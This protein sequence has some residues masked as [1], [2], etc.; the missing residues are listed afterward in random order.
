MSVFFH[1]STEVQSP[2]FRPFLFKICRAPEFFSRRFFQSSIRVCEPYKSYKAGMVGQDMLQ[3]GYGTN[4]VCLIAD[5]TNQVCYKTI[6]LSE[7]SFGL[8]VLHVGLLV[9]STPRVV[10]MA[11][12]AIPIPTGRGKLPLCV[13]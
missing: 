5:A 3:I 11:E 4:P 8:D 9:L 10:L 2:M 1:K 13:S 7:S 6:G 12:T